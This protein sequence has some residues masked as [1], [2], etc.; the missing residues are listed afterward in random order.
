MADRRAPALNRAAHAAL[1]TSNAQTGEVTA[2]LPVLAALTANGL[3]QPYGRT[4][5][6]YL[7]EAGRRLRDQQHPEPATTPDRSTA[8]PVEASQLTAPTSFVPAFGDE[9]LD[10]AAADPRRAR[11]VATAWQGLLEIRRLAGTH[12]IAPIE[13]VRVPWFVA[14][15]LEAGGAPPSATTALARPGQRSRTGYRVLEGDRSD[16]ARVEWRGINQSV[17][18]QD[19]PAQ[20]QRCAN[21]LTRAGWDALLYIGRGGDR[22]LLVSPK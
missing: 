8:S 18:R 12:G 5:R 16:T 20:L 19:A 4:Q 10:L 11:E 13:R 9:P 2:T 3:A 17:A 15:A 14:L 6:H 21:V 22:Y 1:R 7:T